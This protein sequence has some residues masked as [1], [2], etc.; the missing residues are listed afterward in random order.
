MLVNETLGY[1]LSRTVNVAPGRVTS[2]RIDPPKGTLALNASPWAE[3]WVDGDRVRSVTVHSLLDHHDLT[4]AAPYVLDATELGDL[5]KLT[6]TEYVTGA[7]SQKQTG[8]PK[9]ADTPM[10]DNVQGFTWCFPV[11]FD[12]R[13]GADHTIEKPREYERWTDYVPALSPPWPGRS[14][15]GRPTLRPTPAAGRPPG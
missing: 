10:P 11:A 8:E 12:P 4:I 9:A 14:P 13:E 6:K 1:R 15:R 5:L 7:E 2:M 3:V